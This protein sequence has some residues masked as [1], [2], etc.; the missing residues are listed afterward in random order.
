MFS[1]KPQVIKIVTT[2]HG[3]GNVSTAGTSVIR[4]NVIKSSPAST[5]VRKILTDDDNSVG[6]FFFYLVEMKLIATNLTRK[7]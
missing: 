3:K 4:S 5:P 7:T 2:G 1:G 6:E